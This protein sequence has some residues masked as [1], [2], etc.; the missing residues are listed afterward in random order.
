VSIK[1]KTVAVLAA[2]G[3]VLEAQMLPLIP[4]FRLSKRLF[5][6]FFVDIIGCKP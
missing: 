5:F 3:T 4:E 2:Y 1:I 6:F